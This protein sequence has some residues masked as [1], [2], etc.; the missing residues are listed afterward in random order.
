[1]HDIAEVFPPPHLFQDKSSVSYSLILPQALK[2]FPSCKFVW[3]FIKIYIDSSVKE[4]KNV[5]FCIEE[6]AEDRELQTSSSCRKLQP[7]FGCFCSGN[8]SCQAQK[9][10]G[11]MS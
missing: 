3:L 7:R 9:Y 2:V 1:M 6:A 8:S 10:M 5:F 11:E 4:E